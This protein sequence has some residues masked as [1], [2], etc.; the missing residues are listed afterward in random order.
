MT[1]R[2]PKP[3]QPHPLYF[4]ESDMGRLGN[5]FSDLCRDSNSRSSVVALIRSGEIN[6]VRV[7]EVIEPCEDY[8][9][10][11]VTDVTMDLKREANLEFD[12]RVIYC[13]EDMI[14]IWRA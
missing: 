8:P 9:T 3:Q 4:I 13:R 10:G 2:C 1:C 6:P 12:G 11:Q 14:R 7:L 5:W